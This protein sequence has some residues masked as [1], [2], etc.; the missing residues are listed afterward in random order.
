VAPYFVVADDAE[1]IKAHPFFRGVIWDEMHL[2]RPPW[3][4]TIKRDQSLARW[5]ED[6]S[7]IMGTSEDR[8]SSVEVPPTVED[9][10][11]IGLAIT[12]DSAIPAS[13]GAPLPTIEEASATTNAATNRHLVYV[14]EA[15]ETHASTP[16]KDALGKKKKPKVSKRPRDKVL[17]DPVTGPT[18]MAE[19]KAK[20]FLGYTYRRVEG[21]ALSS[22]EERV[23]RTIARPSVYQ[24]AGSIGAV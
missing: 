9:P 1:D 2:S 15:G 16:E 3:I 18:A 20:A 23:G 13:N 11:T 21:F 5:F 19:R 12:A 10:T 22:A 4:P 24:I 17:R 6:E 7:E 8:G 14:N